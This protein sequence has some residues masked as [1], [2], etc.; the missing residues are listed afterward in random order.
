M[1]AGERA[2]K[3]AAILQAN[4]A[5]YQAFSRGD[6]AA[7]GELWA[8]AAP[9]ACLH[10]GAPLLSGRAAVLGSWRQ[11]LNVA[12]SF[13]MVAREP[14]VCLLGD[15]AFVTCL[16]ANGKR[17]AHLIATNVFVWEE[18]RWRMV[19]HHAGPLTTPEPVRAESSKHVN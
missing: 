18:E 14:R 1:D 19:H 5:F 2:Q 12:P 3:E 7:M 10:P 17:P 15:A 11:I 6:F 16:E 13:E 4:Q 9:V 8:R